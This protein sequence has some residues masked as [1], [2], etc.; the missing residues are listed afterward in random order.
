MLRKCDGTVSH[1]CVSHQRQG[2]HRRGHGD[3]SPFPRKNSGDL[4][5]CLSHIHLDHVKGLCSLA[6]ALSMQE[7]RGVVTV[8]ADQSV[9]TALS[10]NVFNNVLWPDFTAIP[11]RK[12]PIVR[13]QAMK[14]SEYTR[15]EGL[16]IRAIPVQHG[17]HTDGFLVKEGDK[18]IMLT[19]DTGM[20]DL[21]W[22]TAKGEDHVAFIIADVAFPNRL[23]PLATAAAHMTLSVLLDRID[24]YG[25]HH[26]PI[27]VAYMKSMFEEEIH[28][29]IRDAGRQNLHVL[30]QGSVLFP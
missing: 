10:E 13:L 4:D 3:R 5:V 7:D 14:P 25:L 19:S 17:A 23:S 29:E 16:R 24:T 8:L 15:V 26:I 18:T 12:N 28:R 20:T 22:E 9:L 6:E 21:F 27:Y 30:E 1:Q 2:A 11:N